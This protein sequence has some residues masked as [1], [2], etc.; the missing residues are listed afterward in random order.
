MTEIFVS[1]IQTRVA[2]SWTKNSLTTLRR[3]RPFSPRTFQTKHVG[4]D[5]IK[6]Q[7]C[8]GRNMGRRRLRLNSVQLSHVKAH[9]HWV[10]VAVKKDL[11]CLL[12]VG[13]HVAPTKRGLELP[14]DLQVWC[15]GI[16]MHPELLK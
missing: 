14:L 15:A 13:R 9:G 5:D 3:A 8:D 4:K 16:H 2:L 10:E 11:Q 7:L 12:L 6:K 1:W